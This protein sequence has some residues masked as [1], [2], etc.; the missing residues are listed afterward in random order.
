MPDDEEDELLDELVRAWVEVY[1][2]S[3]TTRVLL[4]M[5]ADDG[6][7][8]TSTVSETLARRTGWEPTERGLYRTLR[9]LSGLGLLAVH[10]QPGQRTGRQQHVYEITE[11][12]TAYLQRI[13][14]ALV[15]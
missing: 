13:E 5:I 9:R 4:R 3:A 14:A 11:R 2:K 15:T 7:M 8:N 6:P 1:R 12:G 10:A